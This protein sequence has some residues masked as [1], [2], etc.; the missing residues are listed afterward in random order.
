MR[1]LY[2]ILRI[3]VGL[4]FLFSGIAKL[5]PIE[6]F[7]N[8]FIELGV[9]NWTFA[10][11]LAR[12]VIG[13]ELFLGLSIIFNL[14]LKNKVYYLTQGVLV[15]FTAYL[16][17]L[18]FTKGNDVDCGCFGT[19][20]ELSPIAS[21][22]K[23]FILIIAL[24]FIPRQYHNHGHIV[25]IGFALILILSIALPLIL[26]PIEMHNMQGIEVN[27]KVDL[28]ELPPLYKTKNKVDFS[29]G[30]KVVAFLS[31]KCSHCVNAT[32]KLV[33]LDKQQ[34]INNL[35]LVIGSKREE[36]LISFVDDNKPG[37]PIIWMNDN[38]FFK[39][40]GGR[41]PAIFYLE[42]GIMKKKWFGANFD[43][44]D[45]RKYFRD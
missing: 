34:T 5:Y 23:N 24:L 2:H 42:D 16:V 45:I 29:K 17:F 19:L 13:L 27:Q 10:P 6:P 25:K 15:F 38:D 28:S 4:S 43:V 26:N 30:N 12:L 9:S 40:S 31:Y 41:L 3:L 35:Y 39:Y 32:K 21:I 36:G 14:W 22:A 37:F 8:T 1:Y 7:E 20:L 18:L 11:F 33:L 44:E